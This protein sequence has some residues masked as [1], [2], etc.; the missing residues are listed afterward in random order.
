MPGTES[1]L[2]PH[3]CLLAASACRDGLGGGLSMACPGW[4]SAYLVQVPCLD[5]GGRGR[6][7]AAETDKTGASS[8]GGEGVGGEPTT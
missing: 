1:S 2:P 8:E 5:F 3:N 6:W 4:S 7:P